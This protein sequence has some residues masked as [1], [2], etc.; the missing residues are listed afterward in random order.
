MFLQFAQALAYPPDPF[1]LSPQ[2]VTS[3]VNTGASKKL[4]QARPRTVAFSKNV[5]W[6]FA[7]VLAYPPDE[8]SF[9]NFDLPTYL[10][11]CWRGLRLVTSG[12]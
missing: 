7:K 11:V 1:K 6:Q 2:T 8:Q 12:P 5:F 9:V 3:K 10:V 4:Y